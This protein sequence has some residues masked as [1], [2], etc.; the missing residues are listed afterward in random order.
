VKELRETDINGRFHA[1]YPHIEGLQAGTCIDM[2]SKLMIVDDEWLRI[3]SDNL[4]NRSMGVDTE[5]DAVIVAA[6]ESRVQSVIRRFRDSLLAEHLNV[7][8]E[9]VARAVQEH[10]SMARAIDALHSEAR[11]LKPLE[12]LHEWSDTVLNMAAI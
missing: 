10:G 5:C 1:Y 12:T 11:T 8:P 4:S 3:G 6:G 2:H 9:H 7:A